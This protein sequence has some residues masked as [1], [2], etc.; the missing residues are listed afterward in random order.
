M[1]DTVLDKQDEADQR[2]P[3]LVPALR[4]GL[5]ILR[6]L[7]SEQTPLGAPDIVRRLS[8]PRASAFRLLHTLESMNFLVADGDRKFRL[9]PAVLG[10]GFGYLASDD[11]IEVAQ[12]ILRK[13]RDTTG[14]SSHRAILDGSEVVYVVRHAARSTI[15]SSVRVGTRFPVHATVMGRMLVCDFTHAQLRAIYPEDRLPC[16]T[17]QTPAT[18]GELAFLLRDDKARGYAVSQSFFETGVSTVAAPVRDSSGQVVASINVTSVDTH[19]SE[20]QLHGVLKDAV[21]DAAREIGMWLS[22]GIDT[23]ISSP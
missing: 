22:P 20:M 1:T 9:G 5:E 8:L 18:I 12:P 16:F 2:D 23:Q 19:V 6:L 11:L 21:L 4:H 3:Y 15:S 10:L 17:P 7:S 13:L 14:L